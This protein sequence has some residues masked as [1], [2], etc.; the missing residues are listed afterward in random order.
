MIRRFMIDVIMKLA[1]KKVN[2]MN[3]L[4]QIPF[5]TYEYQ[6]TKLKINWIAFQIDFLLDVLGD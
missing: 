4:V 1:E 5:N 6:F 2:E 3:H